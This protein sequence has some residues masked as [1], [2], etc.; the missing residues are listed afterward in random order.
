MFFVGHE[1]AHISRGHVDYWQRERGQ[2]TYSE[3]SEESVATAMLIER[4]CLE[5]DADRRSV[6]T[7]VNSLRDTQSEASFKGLPW[8]GGASHAGS[9][10]RDW[11]VAI[12]IVFR[13]L[14]DHRICDT[15]LRK[16]YPPLLSRWRY[17]EAIA[18]YGIDRFWPIEER[19]AALSSIVA[20]R[21]DL[22]R[23]FGT[24]IGNAV[25]EEPEPPP[26]DHLSM[27]QNYWN[28]TLLQ[29][30]SPYSYEF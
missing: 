1:I 5:L 8:S 18:R 24:I 19:E 21:H 7:S 17:A 22:A 14:G 30:V 2:S 4:Q 28:H 12:A 3:N 16:A 23:A 29:K 13:L 15:N 26:A 6:M 11:S 25:R 10:F 9:L 27:L 20:G